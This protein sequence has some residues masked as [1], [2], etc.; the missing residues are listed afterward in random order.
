M[1][2]NYFIR[3]TK[4][5]LVSREDM[6]R[7][8]ED[9]RIAIHFPGE[10]ANNTGDSESL[11]PDD[12]TK[13]DEKGA[14]RVFREIAEQGGYIWAQSYVS[15]RAKVGY[16]RGLCEGGEGVELD[17]SA[18]WELRGKN[19][20][21]RDNGYLATLKTLRMEGIG[22]NGI[23]E[24]GKGEQMDLRA[25]RP[26]RVA[27]SRWKVGERLREV[28]EGRPR[29]VAFSSLSPAEQEAACAE[30]LRERHPGRGDLPILKRLLLPVGR[31]LEDVDIFG[32]AEDGAL[33]Y[34]QVTNHPVG[35]SP[36][37]DKA[38]R[39]GAYRNA[40][41]NE[42]GADVRKGARLVFFGVGVSSSDAENISYVSVDEEVEPWMLSDPD[43]RHG[44]FG[45]T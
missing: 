6:E 30:F 29:N 20:P 45:R 12:Y 32:V 38:A 28:A 37:K 36:A 42:A 39:L 22:P 15:N 7:L 24:V 1:S 44:L 14:I 35:S 9:D 34:A 11:D 25:R 5:I 17:K 41:A 27:V 16:V 4:G 13:R 31:S 3:H 19:Y 33:V 23:V 43:H 18:R 21:G 26:Q 10:T 8:W 2:G 40:Y